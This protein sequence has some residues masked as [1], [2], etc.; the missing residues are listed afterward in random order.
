MRSNTENHLQHLNL[1]VLFHVKN[2]IKVIQTSVSLKLN[3]DQ[4]HLKS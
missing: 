4:A 2:F 3:K 1:S